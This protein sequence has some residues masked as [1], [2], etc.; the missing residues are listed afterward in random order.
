MNNRFLID[1][2]PEEWEAVLDGEEVEC[3]SE[4]P[5]GH[6]PHGA[7]ISTFDPTEWEAPKN[8]AFRI[9]KPQMETERG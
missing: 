7:S 6:H 9:K 3:F 8:I 2:F 1:K 4:I 5:D